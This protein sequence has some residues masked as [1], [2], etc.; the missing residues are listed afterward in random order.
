D[1]LDQLVVGGGVALEHH[2]A[3]DMHVRGVALEVQEGA[4]ESGQAV[5]IGHALDSGTPPAVTSLTQVGSSSCESRR[6][7]KRPAESS[8]PGAERS[9]GTHRRMAVA[10]RHGANRSPG[11]PRRDRSDLSM[12]RCLTAALRD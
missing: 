7:P 8:L 6:L 1:L 4:V 9:G 12:K 2:A 10:H 3:G 5:G 11:A